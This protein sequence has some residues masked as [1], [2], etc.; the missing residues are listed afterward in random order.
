LGYFLLA[1]LVLS[2]FNLYQKTSFTLFNGRLEQKGDEI[3]GV[4]CNLPISQIIGGFNIVSIDSYFASLL[5][6]D[7]TEIKYLVYAQEPKLGPAD[8]GEFE[9]TWV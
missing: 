7:F 3:K 8:P 4:V 6:H 5:G 2:G 9:A 1:S